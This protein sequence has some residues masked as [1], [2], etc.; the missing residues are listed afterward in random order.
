MLGNQCKPAASFQLR[1][2][3]VVSSMHYF[4]LKSQFD[5]EQSLRFVNKWFVAINLYVAQKSTHSSPCIFF[6]DHIVALQLHFRETELFLFFIFFE[7]EI[8]NVI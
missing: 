1:I 7:K 4:P 6:D 8:F 5:K 2:W 3:S